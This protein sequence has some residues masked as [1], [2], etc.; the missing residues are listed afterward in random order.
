M[1]GW[2]VIVPL[3]AEGARKTRLSDHLSKL[4][5]ERLSESLFHH[6]IRTLR[7][8]PSVARIVLLSDGPSPIPDL[9]WRHDRGR[10]LNA[11][12]QGVIDAIRGKNDASRILIVHGDLPLLNADDIEIL[13]AA[14]RDRIAIAPDR[15]GDGTNALALGDDRPFTLCFGPNSFARHH[16]Q[17]P[18]AAIVIGRPG[19][20][21]DV[22]TP[23]DLQ[24]AA[25]LGFSER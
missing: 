9:E 19:L 5:R 2:T 22:D 4:A 1:T 23:A 12:L 18:D 3:K 13:A 17:A 14:A 8:C 11:E 6:V 25:A 24:A 7:L 15:G 20:A 16:A 10:G 21:L